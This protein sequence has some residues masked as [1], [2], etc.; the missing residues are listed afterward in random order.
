MAIQV[1]MPALSPTMTEGTIAKWLKQVGDAIESGDVLCEIE[2]DKATMEVESIDEGTM[3]KI[4]VP[5]GTEGVLVNALIAVI[6][7]E[8]E[9]D[10]AADNV[11]EASAPS[12]EPVSAPVVDALVP[13]PV[14]PAPALVALAPVALALALARALA[15][16]LVAPAPAALALVPALGAVGAG[17][18]GALLPPRSSD[19]RSQQPLQPPGRTACTRRF[20]RCSSGRRD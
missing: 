9:D 15:L 17:T 2:T 5:E 19:S 1:L 14:A 16:A 18:A 7:E 11:V 10:S 12:A 8:G 6:L 4:L 13:A 3:G 20:S